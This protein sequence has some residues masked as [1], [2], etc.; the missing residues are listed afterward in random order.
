MKDEIKWYGAIGY[1][2][3]YTKTPR[4]TLNSLKDR[5]TKTITFTKDHLNKLPY[6]DLVENKKS[7]YDIHINN[8]HARFKNL[9]QPHLDNGYSIVFKWE[10]KTKVLI[11]N[12]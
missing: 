1:S 5:T 12:K 7:I 4:K 9:T 10:N 11:Y 8:I 6:W 3:S 2:E